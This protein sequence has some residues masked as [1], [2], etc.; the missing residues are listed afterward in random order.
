MIL[1]SNLDKGP[2]SVLAWRQDIFHSSLIP[3]HF[4]C[5]PASRFITIAKG[6]GSGSGRSPQASAMRLLPELITSILAL[7]TTFAQAQQAADPDRL[8]GTWT[9][10]S[11]KVLT[12]PVRFPFSQHTSENDDDS[13]AIITDGF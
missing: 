1:H 3:L 11:R 2:T 7:T 13:A 9:T 6:S 12:G 5:H 4:A 10:K 8:T